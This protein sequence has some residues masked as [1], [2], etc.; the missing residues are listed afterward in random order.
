METDLECLSL[1][2]LKSDQAIFLSIIIPVFNEEATLEEILTRVLSITW[3]HPVEI[4]VVDDHSKDRSPE[5]LERFKDRVSVIRHRRNRGKGACIQTAL[6]ICRG[7][8]VV[9]Q[10]ADLEY[11]PEE[12]NLLVQAVDEGGYDVVYGSR[13]REK[14]NSFSQYRSFYWGNQFLTW[15]TNRMTRLRLTDME[16]C[17]KLIR[18][19][20][21]NGLS[22]NENGFGIE[23]EITCKLAKLK[24]LRWK[25]VAITYRGR[26]RKE[27]KKIKWSDGVKAV[28]IILK[29]TWPGAK[30]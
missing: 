16:T 28:Y 12:L 2:P 8:Y 29:H 7:E 14:K 24:G 9:I 5:I 4:I 13:F 15:L 20:L 25:E 1:R 11:S 27:G 17:Y 18:R 19:Q 10:D 30:F 3:S 23:P 21:L 22:F 6:N 26:S